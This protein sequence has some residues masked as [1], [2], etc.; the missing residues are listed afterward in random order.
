LIVHVL[1][2]P[3]KYGPLR[4]TVAGDEATGRFAPP[5]AA[6]PA[7]ERVDVR[8]LERIRAIHGLSSTASD[9]L[10]ELGYRL[11]VPA[12]T[13]PRRVTSGA[14]LVGYAVTLRYLPERADPAHTRATGGASKLAHHSAFAL[15]A[16]TDVLVID[17]GGCPVASTLGG[18]AAAAAVAA[19]L[20]GCIVDGGVRDI[21]EIAELG[22]PVWA[23]H[24]T[25]VTGKFRLE[26]AALNTPI[27]CAGV[28]VRPG[29]L[30]L[31]D[32]TGI[33]FVPPAV[34]GELI[35]R[36]LEVS[37][38]ENAHLGGGGENGG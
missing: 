31:A 7:F 27:S 35:A 22:L 24:A 16:A 11:A 15:A 9:V 37:Q 12:S 18:M 30:V 6:S 8:L 29:D 33:C 2:R 5:A 32:D 20:G 3:D 19:G 13:I 25:P 1:N 36:V 34:A 4:G 14:P 23:R 26:A 28:Q 21:D 17:A 10:D 38:A